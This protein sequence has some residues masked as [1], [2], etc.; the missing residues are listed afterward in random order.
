MLLLPDSLKVERD[1]TVYK[2]HHTKDGFRNVNLAVRQPTFDVMF[3][4]LLRRTTTNLKN[5]IYEL[6][7]IENVGNFLKENKSISTVTWVGHSTL[8]VQMDG[9]NFLTDPVWSEKIG[10]GTP[11]DSPR[12]NKP[13]LDIQKLPK[14]D[15]IL[16]SHDHYDHLDKKTI[17]TLAQN[18]SVLFVVPLK[19]KGILDEWGVQNVVELDWGDVFEYRTLKIYC[20]EAQHFSGRGL[21]R[22][23]TLWASFCII[24]NSKRFYYAGDSGYWKHFSEIGEKLGPFDLAAL[25]IGAYLPPEIMKSMHLSPESAVK[26]YIDLK[27][28][29]FVPIHYGTFVLSDEPI[30]EPIRLLKEK[31]NEKN[32]K[33]DNFYILKLGETKRW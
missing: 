12:L 10:P 15:F 28:K 21:S 17:L 4:F 13:G 1:K 29:Y 25:P 3:P 32:L 2:Y 7:R 27:A 8:L 6:P 26:A 19:V 31:V 30:D 20:T 5:P 9:V 23:K 22:N 33:E 16:I 14:I 24:G 18:P 11:F